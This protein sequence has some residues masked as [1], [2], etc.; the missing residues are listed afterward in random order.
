[1]VQMCF[2]SFLL[3]QIYE[4]TELKN[5]KVMFDDLVSKVQSSRDPNLLLYI[6]EDLKNTTHHHCENHEHGKCNCKEPCAHCHC[7]EKAEKEKQQD[8]ANNKKIFDLNN[9][10]QVAQLVSA[11]LDYLY[12][13][14]CV[15]QSFAE[16]NGYYGMTFTVS[17]DIEGFASS[18]YHCAYVRNKLEHVS[19]QTLNTL[20]SCEPEKPLAVFTEM[21]KKER[22]RIARM[23][24]DLLTTDLAEISHDPYTD[25]KALVL[26]PAGQS[27][28]RYL[29]VKFSNQKTL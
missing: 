1:M 24:C 23:C 8:D 27:A 29:E 18:A 28:A 13:L 16:K 14:G 20:I 21:N 11:S 22:K 15:D 25:K 17:E 26:T 19:P 6:K 9:R 3:A 12:D 5:N 2:S 10:Q 4:E 7:K